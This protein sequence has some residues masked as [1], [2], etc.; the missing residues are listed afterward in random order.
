MI[1]SC[2]KQYCDL[3]AECLCSHL[4]AWSDNHRCW[5]S[6]RW[7]LLC[8]PLSES[9]SL[10]WHLLSS[11]FYLRNRCSASTSQFFDWQQTRS[12][13]LRQG[14][15]TPSSHHEMKVHRCH[16]CKLLGACQLS[17]RRYWEPCDL[18]LY[19]AYTLV[20]AK[21]VFWSYPCCQFVSSVLWNSSC[22][23]SSPHCCSNCWTKGAPIQNH[24][25]GRCLGQGSSQFQ[26]SRRFIERQQ[27]CSC[28]RGCRLRSPGGWPETS[29]KSSNYWH[30][31]QSSGLSKS[32]H[33]LGF[34]SAVVFLE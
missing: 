27:N 26:Q 10:C 1:W 2:V 34:P 15:E 4:Y 12:W 24:G 5:L 30:P 20:K 32:F 19:D 28:F 22:C 21:T 16:Y 14:L 3:A 25:L 6:S 9:W 31:L 13:F 18:S 23:C 11:S 8:S 17:S 29:F 33:F 7:G